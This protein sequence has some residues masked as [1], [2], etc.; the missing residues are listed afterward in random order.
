MG[1]FKDV[2]SNNSDEKLIEILSNRNKYQ[3]IAVDAAI[4]ESIDRKIIIDINDLEVKYPM[5]SIMAFQNEISKQELISAQK[6]QAENDM[7]YGALW[8]IGGIIATAAHIGFIF[9]GAI[10][11][12][13]IQFFRG[14]INSK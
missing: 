10:L 5:S 13:G 1:S 7:L 3:D 8:C 2:M 14:L 4:K 11:F 9:W 12:G 6:K